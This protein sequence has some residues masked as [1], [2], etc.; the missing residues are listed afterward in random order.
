MNI[1]K[2]L[3]IL[4]IPSW[5][6]LFEGHIGGS[7]FREQALALR[8]MGC[9][10]GVIFPQ[11]RSVKNFFS[12]KNRIVKD[13]DQGL[14]TYREHFV[15]FTPRWKSAIEKKWIKSGE[16][17][18]ELYVKEN[19]MP[20]IIHA[21]SLFNGGLLALHISE[22]Y[23]I[24]FVLTEHSTAFARNLVTDKQISKAAIAVDKAASCIAVSERF[25]ILLNTKFETKK[26]SYIPN[27]VNK[28]FLDAPLH[29]VRNKKDCY[30]LINICALEPKKR[31][32][33]LIKAFAI[34]SKELDNIVLE[35]GGDGSQMKNLIDLTG[36]LSISDK[37][38]FLGKLTRSDV[39]VKVSNADAFILSSE[40]ETF[41]VV[42]V[43]AL[44]LGKPIIATKC[45]GPESIINDEVGYL[46]NKNSA[47]ELASAIKLLYSNQENFEAENI[48]SYCSREF[49]GES[50]INK[51]INIYKSLLDKNE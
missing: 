46:V 25:R 16:R 27:I 36:R 29:R 43:E 21:H 13:I 8:A 47:S 9:N 33:L 49:S 30:R 34:A 3:H 6:P 39:L 42:L 38:T 11:M 35:I 40:Y 51:L 18:F 45:G 10:I 15:N 22:K 4:I 44:A 19:G 1:H 5:Y 50:V 17:L 2:K 12:Q 7:F 32:D 26:W 23:K 20:D 28:E 24:P 48:R 14:V 41:G 31:V 37:V